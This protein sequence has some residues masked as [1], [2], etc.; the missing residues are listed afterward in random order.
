MTLGSIIALVE[1][2]MC[3]YSVFRLSQFHPLAS[4]GWA[5]NVREHRHSRML[6]PVFMATIVL[7]GPVFLFGVG[8]LVYAELK[9]A[10]PALC[11][12]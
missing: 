10:K 11:S 3:S 6:L 9:S 12:R 2:A 4:L 7:G 1:K 5:G 8:Q